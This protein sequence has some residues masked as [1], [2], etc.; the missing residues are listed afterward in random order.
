MYYVDVVNCE[1]LAKKDSKNIL[2]DR[3]NHLIGLQ[4]LD[5]QE[6]IEALGT[7]PFLEYLQETF[8]LKALSPCSELDQF[9]IGL[10][11]VSTNEIEI[12]NQSPLSD[13]LLRTPQYVFRGLES[14]KLVKMPIG[15]GLSHKQQL[16]IPR[17][18]EILEYDGNLSI[19]QHENDT[20]RS[21]K[22]HSTGH[23]G[24]KEMIPK[25]NIFPHQV[26]EEP[27]VEKVNHAR[28]LLKYF[29]NYQEI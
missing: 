16:N 23:N 20:D 7:T 14:R 17:I 13:A 22:D 29:I 1:G 11:G 9:V 27:K 26:I 5:V 28:Q 3:W 21:C 24:K 6:N 2:V 18:D 4:Q 10:D 25:L 8:L 12:K 19:S 15:K